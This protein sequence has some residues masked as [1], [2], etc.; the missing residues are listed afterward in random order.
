[1]EDPEPCAAEPPVPDPDDPL[2]PE[3]VEPPEPDDPDEPV[4]TVAGF[5]APEDT[6]TPIPAPTPI[7]NPPSAM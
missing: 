4:L 1:M 7:A 2:P 3:S 5:F 6:S